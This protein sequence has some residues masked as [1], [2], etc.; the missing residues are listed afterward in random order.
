MTEQA[1]REVL[2]I[3]RGDYEEGLAALNQIENL[4]QFDDTIDYHARAMR[5]DKRSH[6]EFRLRLIDEALSN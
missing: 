5:D 4:A 3:I 1:M 2:T 6:I